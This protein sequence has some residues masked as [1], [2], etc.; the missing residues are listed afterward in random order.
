MWYHVTNKES[1]PRILEEGLKPRS[2]TGASMHFAPQYEGVDRFVYLATSLPYASYVYT[3]LRGSAKK[4]NLVMLYVSESFLDESLLRPDDDWFDQVNK[5]RALRRF[6]DPD[7]VLDVTYPK[8]PDDNFILK[9]KEG[10]LIQKPRD[11]KSSKDLYIWS[12]ALAPAWK[13]SKELVGAVA[14][15]GAIPPAALK[16]RRHSGRPTY[17]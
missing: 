13:D 5:E 16:I 2:S 1:L 10:T 3:A 17:L 8:H 14:Y 12:R 6:A 9:T 7:F 15:E 4:S 11:V